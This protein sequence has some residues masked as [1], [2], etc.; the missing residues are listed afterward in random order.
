MNMKFLNQE[1]IELG[2]YYRKRQSARLNY[3]L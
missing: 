3:L 1:I 2:R